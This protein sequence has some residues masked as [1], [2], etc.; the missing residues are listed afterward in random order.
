MR[1]CF[2]LRVMPFDGLGLSVNTPG[3]LPMFRVQ[4]EISGR[5]G[6]ALGFYEELHD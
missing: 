1:T 2:S 6:E 4:R 5:E 3:I